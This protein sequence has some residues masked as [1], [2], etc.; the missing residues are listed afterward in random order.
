MTAE[1]E[2]LVSLQILRFIA[3][4]MVVMAHA[5]IVAQNSIGHFEVAERAASVGV[6]GV[7]IFFVLSG[8]VIMLTGPLFHPR[9]TA[10]RFA[11]RR[12]LRVVPVFWFWSAV[13][14]L[15]DRPAIAWPQTWAT[16]FLPFATGVATA[17]YLAAGW[18]LSFEMAFYATVAALMIGGK[19][20]RNLAIGAIA[21]AA[22][23]AARIFAPDAFT[24]FLINPLFLDF[25]TGALLAW[26]LPRLS[27]LPKRIG[28]FLL[29]AAVLLLLPITRPG[30][31]ARATVL[32]GALTGNVV[33]RME[34]F[35]L[36]A[37]FM[38]AGAAIVDHLCVGRW[39][40]RLAWM[41]DASYSIYL[42]HTL[43]IEGVN[44]IA[45]GSGYAVPPAA[46][47]VAAIFASL[48]SGALAH[49][50]IERP[51]LRELKRL[52]FDRPPW[53]PAV[54]ETPT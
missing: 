10:A 45:R 6:G 2:R 43:A 20:R 7:D 21:L 29:V 35:A 8:M 39:A 9:P 44:A 17:P 28:F 42:V 41:G 32:D 47:F 5:G 36:P 11:L 33:S 26:A 24:L 3:A 19:T 30:I 37:V 27:K 54:V 51:I 31:G 50:F 1:R 15:I 53:R 22:M 40:K 48:A 38:V 34:M 23:I 14:I 4:L 16:L 25:G 52:S 18:T 12:F 49:R 13:T 46:F